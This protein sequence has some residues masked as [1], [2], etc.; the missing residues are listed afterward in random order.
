[1][2]RQETIK[3]W[4]LK[5]QKQIHTNGCTCTH[6]WTHLQGGN[7]LSGSAYIDPLTHY[8]WVVIKKLIWSMQTGKCGDRH[9]VVYCCSLHTADLYL[10][11]YEWMSVCVYP[12]VGQSQKPYSRWPLG[13]R[14]HPDIL[15]ASSNMYVC[16]CNIPLDPW[17]CVQ[18]YQL[19]L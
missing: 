19:F 1:M 3:K 18:N 4:K 17:C 14:K 8:C 12:C 6:F 2:T 11:M 13:L 7:I 15:C 10:Y 9:W 5:K 16:V